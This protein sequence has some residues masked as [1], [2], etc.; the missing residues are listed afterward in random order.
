M[1]AVV[2]RMAAATARNAH[3]RLHYAALEAR[4]AAYR[5]EHGLAPLTAAEKVLASH[6]A[7]PREKVRHGRPRA[8]LKHTPYQPTAMA[9]PMHVCVCVCVGTLGV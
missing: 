1:A 9:W 3:R 5:D 7:D 6:L 8:S 2:Q 4:L